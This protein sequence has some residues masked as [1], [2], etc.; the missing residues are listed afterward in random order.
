[1]SEEEGELPQVEEE[2][3]DEVLETA[4][5]GVE[6]ERFLSEDRIGRAI[7][8]RAREDMEAAQAELVEVNPGDPSAV[9]AAQFKYKVAASVIGWLRDIIVEG[10]NARQ[11]VESS[12]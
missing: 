8:K 9:R 6:V 12:E 10:Q 2:L 4:V 1:L 3:S 7:V 5:F 11:I